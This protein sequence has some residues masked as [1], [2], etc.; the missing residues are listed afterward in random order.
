MAPGRRPSPWVRWAEGPRPTPAGGPRPSYGRRGRSSADCCHR[1]SGT[2]FLRAQGTLNIP[3]PREQT[4]V[5]EQSPNNVWDS[6]NPFT[7]NGEAYNYGYAIVCREYLF[8][9]DLLTGTMT[10]WLATGYTYNPDY[11]ECTL[12]LNPA[13]KWSDG[14]PFTSDDVVFT[15]NMLLQTPNLNGADRAILDIASVSASDPQTVVFALKAPNPRFHYRFIA[16]IIG[17]DMR[18]V[19]KHIWEGQDPNSFQFNPPVQTGPYTLQESTSTGLY[20]LWAKNPNYWNSAVLDPAPQ[21]VMYVQSSSVDTSVQEFLAGNLDV[22][23]NI[24]YL[25]QQVVASQVDTIAQFAYPDPNPRAFHFNSD[26]PTGLFATGAGKWAMSYL[27]DRETYANT[28]WQPTSRPASYPWADYASWAPWAPDSVMSKFDFSYST[29]MANQALDALG[30][31]RDG[32][33]RSLNGKPLVLDMITPVTSSSAEFAL[34]N[35]LVEA[36]KGVGIQISHRSLPGSA[37]SDAWQTGQ[38]DISNHWAGGMALDPNQMYTNYH[39]RNYRPL[40]QR[41]NVFN[42]VRLRDP[43]LDALIDQLANVDPSDQANRPTF[44]QALDVWMTDLPYSSTIQTLYAQL[45]STQYWTGWPTDDN[46]F[47]N[48][49]SWWGH[50]MFTIGGVKPAGGQ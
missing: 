39:S 11:T 46:P 34:G 40:G 22:S 41:T 17:D 18:I 36:A 32:D 7:V 27:M 31:T 3:T 30:S 10:P 12:S 29:D 42:E 9:L 38:F 20:Y 50:F 44:D 2:A 1:R 6:F 45:F 5:V 25:N 33:T 13:V 26:S 23:N 24:D 14:Q 4:F 16:S 28:I 19:P 47:A 8:Y 43:Q 48:P 15:Q 49:L 35:A 21:Y 37:W